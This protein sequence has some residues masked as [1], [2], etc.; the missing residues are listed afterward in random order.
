[1]RVRLREPLAR[2]EKATTGCNHANEALLNMVLPNRFP[3]FRKS[4]GKPPGITNMLLLSMT[5]SV[6]GFSVDVSPLT[7]AMMKTFTLGGVA[8]VP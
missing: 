4:S 2:I 5:P 7:F 1:M 3:V 6:V 8:D